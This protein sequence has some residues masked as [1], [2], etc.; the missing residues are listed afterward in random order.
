MVITNVRCDN[1]VDFYN[2]NHFK[3]HITAD[4]WLVG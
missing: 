3:N 4:T 1:L 2:N